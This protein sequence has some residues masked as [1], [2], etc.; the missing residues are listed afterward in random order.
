MCTRQYSIISIFCVVI[1]PC[2]HHI[3]VLTTWNFLAL[4][5]FICTGKVVC[6]SSWPNKWKWQRI[7]I[8]SVFLTCSR[9]IQ[10]KSKLWPHLDK[11]STIKERPWQKHVN[12]FAKTYVLHGSNTSRIDHYHRSLKWVL[13][14]KGQFVNLHSFHARLK[15]HDYVRLYTNNVL[16]L[17]AVTIYIYS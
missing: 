2:I 5:S 12:I 10:G 7:C 13:Q 4:V 3:F 8:H 16:I 6:K 14:S 15:H 9:I 17:L 11:T 1:S